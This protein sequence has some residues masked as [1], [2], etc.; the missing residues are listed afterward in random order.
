MQLVA[1]RNLALLDEQDHV[2]EQWII[3]ID[4]VHSRELLDDL[5]HGNL[6]DFCIGI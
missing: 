3:L 5:L 2:F 6:I 1:V 4:K